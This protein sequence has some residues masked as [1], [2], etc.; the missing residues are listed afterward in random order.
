MQSSAL[1]TALEGMP[2]VE[3]AALAIGAP[4]F[5]ERWGPVLVEGSDTEVLGRPP[6]V[7]WNA[8]TPA[9]F[10]VFH[11]GVRQ[12]RLFTPSDGAGAAPV[13][14]VNESF[15]RRFL[16]QGDPLGTRLKLEAV[17]STS[18]FTVVGVVEDM[19]LGGGGALRED[20]VYLP[21]SQT[22]E[23]EVM[24]LV[25][26]EGD[27]MA[28]P[29]ELRQRVAQMDPGIPVWS[30]RTLAEAHAYLIRVP[31]AMGS[32]ALGGG[33]AG[34]VVAAV[35]LYGLLAFRVRQRRRELGLRLA[36]GADG[37]ALARGVLAMAM[38]QLL[39]AVAL[40]L[41]M[42]WIGA[43]LIAVALLGGDPRSPL[44]FVGVAL[45]F[46]GVGL[47]A[48]SGPALRAAGLD[49]ARILRGE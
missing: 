42:A 16:P 44:V 10:E 18:W 38:R 47:V 31:R 24:A 8:V 15:V 25:R 35:G 1:E 41:G 6:S 7:L 29:G 22:D 13:A 19:E 43:P 46:L 21:L 23:G 11:T 14:V 26:A 49:P 5:M 30:I 27:P 2:G 4:G 45:A 33:V 3:T 48:A 28:I 36:L 37:A 12:G 20:R 39:P 32:M 40:G 17:D 9:F 34:L